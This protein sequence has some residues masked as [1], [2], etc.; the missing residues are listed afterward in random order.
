[1]YNRLNKSVQNPGAG[2]AVLIGG[3][4]FFL[5]LISFLSE[6]MLPKF[7]DMQRGLRIIYI[8]QAVF[9]FIMPA[10]MESV[11]DTRLTSRLLAI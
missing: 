1:M 4:I 9:V 2:L 6:W 3:Y 10:I 5:C 11:V 8:L 7:S